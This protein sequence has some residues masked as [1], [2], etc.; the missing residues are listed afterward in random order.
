LNATE[1]RLAAASRM[2]DDLHALRHS[3]SDRFRTD[4]RHRREA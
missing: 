1:R 3:N 4:A 2:K